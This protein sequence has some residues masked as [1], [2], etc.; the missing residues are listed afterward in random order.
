MLLLEE[1]LDQLIPI[2]SADTSQGG[3]GLLPSTV[4]FE[5]LHNQILI[6]W[7]AGPLWP[8]WLQ[9]KATSDPWQSSSSPQGIC[10]LQKKV[11]KSWIRIPSIPLKQDQ[12]SSIL[13]IL[14]VLSNNHVVNSANSL[15]TGFSHKFP[16]SL[17]FNHR[18]LHA[19]VV[20]FLDPHLTSPGVKGGYQTL[21]LAAKCWWRCDLSTG[22]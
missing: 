21:N 19:F 20:D 13:S 22:I 10:E 5:P 4:T 12:E 11:V 18:D 9:T 17:A 2:H 14:H 8:P 1:I 15:L 3:V 6:H 16:H 7:L